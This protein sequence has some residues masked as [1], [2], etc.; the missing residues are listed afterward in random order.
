MRFVI[1]ATVIALGASWASVAQ[2]SWSPAVPCAHKP[3]K[4]RYDV[5]VHFF[6]KNWR[7]SHGVW[8]CRRTRE[9]GRWYAG[10]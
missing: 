9:G 10:R 5:P 8:T 7:V 2:A 3:L 6:S 4:V 1:L